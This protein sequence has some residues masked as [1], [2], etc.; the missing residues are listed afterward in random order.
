M[1]TFLLF[2]RKKCFMNYSDN[3]LHCYTSG[4]SVFRVIVSCL[5]F[6][7]ILVIR[8]YLLEY[9]EVTDYGPLQYIN[10]AS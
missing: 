3:C 8:N 4:I 9:L 6:K 2:T 7:K 5:Q 10:K 1:D